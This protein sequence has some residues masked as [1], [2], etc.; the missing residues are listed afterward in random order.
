MISSAQQIL[1][2]IRLIGS[3]I[4]QF[5][6]VVD[7]WQLGNR[8]RKLTRAKRHFCSVLAPAA[9]LQPVGSK[10]KQNKSRGATNNHHIAGLYSRYIYRFEVCS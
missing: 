5:K 7:T 8:F 9:V 3:N 2:S 4:K 10:C 1:T 6:R